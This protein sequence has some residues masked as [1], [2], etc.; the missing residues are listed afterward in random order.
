MA[1]A[2][3]GN[4]PPQSHRDERDILAHALAS[5][6]LLGTCTS[7]PVHFHEAARAFEDVLALYAPER[8]L[9]EVPPNGC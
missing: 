3:W 9:R 4:G 1:T 2:N 7:L 8:A 6:R 5:T